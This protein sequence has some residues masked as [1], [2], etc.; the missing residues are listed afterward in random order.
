MEKRFELIRQ[1]FPVTEQFVYL[2]NAAV[3]PSPP[4]VVAEAKRILDGYSSHGGE[5]EGQWHGRIA[6]I[7]GILAE[8]LGARSG[9]IFLGLD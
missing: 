2:N 3:A 8:L 9:E 7:R 4:F 5:L 6:E 1:K